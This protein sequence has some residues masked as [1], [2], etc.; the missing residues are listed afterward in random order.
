MVKHNNDIQNGSKHN[1][2]FYLPK[3]TME[4]QKNYRGRGDKEFP[5]PK[6]ISVES[7]CRM[8]DRVNFPSP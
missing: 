4:T 7:H 8:N 2:W 5:K 6:V 3:F 1:N